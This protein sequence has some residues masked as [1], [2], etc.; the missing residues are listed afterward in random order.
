MAGAKKDMHKNALTAMRIPSEVKNKLQEIAKKE[1]RSFNYI[2]SRILTDFV[3]K[4]FK[5]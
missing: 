3:S 1:D 5:H 4:K 2:V